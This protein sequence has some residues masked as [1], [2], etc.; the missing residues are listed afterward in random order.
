[1]PSKTRSEARYIALW[2]SD[3]GFRKRLHIIGVRLS[4]TKPEIRMATMMTARIRE[5]DVP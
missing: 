1:M 2:R 3:G 5:T 4:E